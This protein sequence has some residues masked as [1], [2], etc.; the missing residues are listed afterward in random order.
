[1]LQQAVIPVLERIEFPLGNIFLSLEV[2][3]GCSDASEFR[4][5]IVKREGLGYGG[6]KD[7]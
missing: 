3:A 4:A 5:G 6:P 1:M 7:S 2:H